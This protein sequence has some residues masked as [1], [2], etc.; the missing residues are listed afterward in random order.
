MA[1]IITILFPGMQDLEGVKRVHSL[2][3][4]YHDNFALL[5]C[6]SAYPTPAKEAN[7]RAISTM[8]QEFPLTLMGYSGHEE[9]FNLTLAAVAL[10]A[11]VGTG[12]FRI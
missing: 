11:K 10:G 4:K 2:V 1:T 5:H 9:G 3:E 8:Q 6:V 7:L 12:I